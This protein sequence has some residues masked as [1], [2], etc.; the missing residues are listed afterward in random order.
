MNSSARNGG[1]RNKGSSKGT[2]SFWSPPSLT[3]RPYGAKNFPYHAVFGASHGY[4]FAGRFG[5]HF[6]G[7]CG[8]AYNSGRVANL[9][10]LAKGGL[11]SR[12][13]GPTGRARR[14]PSMRTAKRGRP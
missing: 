1:R 6:R 4:A 10:G 12:T 14:S 2:N 5:G 13:P 8:G 3:L 9:L 7:H 11:T